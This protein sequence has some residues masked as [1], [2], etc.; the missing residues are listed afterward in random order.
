MNAVSTLAP[1]AHTPSKHEV[2]RFER[3][4]AN[5]NRAQ[6]ELTDC[7]ENDE[8]ES[9]RLVDIQT[10][11]EN[12]IFSLQAVNLK[13][14]LTK[15]EIILSNCGYVQ[16]EDLHGIIDDVMRL[17]GIDRSPTFQP[18]VWLYYFRKWGG[19]ACQQD[20]KVVLGCPAD[21]TSALARLNDLT[22]YERAAVIDY[23]KSAE[24]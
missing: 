14:V 19:Q 8:D 2:E 18:H 12:A 20:G 21:A 1:S 15:L 13:A 3:L 11:F 24:A 9:D 22:D 5:Y 6:I 10:G 7:D 17:G 4:L 16:A 23:L